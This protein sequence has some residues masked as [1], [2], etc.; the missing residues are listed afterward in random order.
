[1]VKKSPSREE[2]DNAILESQAQSR[3]FDPN[4]ITFRA[5]H[6]GMSVAEAQDE[7]EKTRTAEL[8]PL[9]WLMVSYGLQGIV[10]TEDQA[11]AE[12][13]RAEEEAKIRGPLTAEECAKIYE[14]SLYRRGR[15]DRVG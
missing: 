2:I 1:M 12:I 11:R 8:S 5:I 3:A 7:Y 4:G 10:I 6:E 14:E 15:D 9:E 13:A